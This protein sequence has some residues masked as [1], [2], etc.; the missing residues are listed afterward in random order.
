VIIS[1]K[2]AALINHGINLV[3]GPVLIN[4]DQTELP[5]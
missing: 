4:M 1:E 5:H 3:I 2:S